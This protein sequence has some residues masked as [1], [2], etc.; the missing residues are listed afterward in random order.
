MGDKA[1]PPR[2]QRQRC[3]RGVQPDGRIGVEQAE[4]VRADQSHSVAAGNADHLVLQ[5]PARGA[6]FAEPGGD[7]HDAAHPAGTAGPHHLG[8]LTCRHRDDREVRRHRQQFGRL[9]AGD[10]KHRGV[11]RIHRE[12][13]AGEPAVKNVAQDLMTDR[14]RPFAGTD[15]RHHGRGQQRTETGLVGGALAGVD[16]AHRLL[17]GRQ[18][19]GDLR[20]ATVESHHGVKPGVAHHMHGQVVLHENI[21]DEFADARSAGVL[22]QM[23]D[24]QRAEPD[25]LVGIG[26]QQRQLRGFVGQPLVGRDADE[27]PADPR[28]QRMVR[29]PRRSPEPSDVLVRRAAIQPEEAQVEGTVGRLDMQLAQGIQVGRQHPSDVH[30]AAVGAH[31]IDSA[32]F[33]DRHSS[34]IPHPP[35]RRRGLTVS[36]RSP[37]RPREGR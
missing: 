7:H 27:L 15:H 13:L 18:V 20:G 11:P 26:D 6:G 25:V 29:G 1:Q 28:G 9:D 32:T 36:I 5:D 33:A 31:G 12:C 17:I 22:G 30:E 14:R 4:A 16:R 3:E 19:D 2:L 24:Q 34:T 21:R 37:R 8:D 35:C 23:L 10:A